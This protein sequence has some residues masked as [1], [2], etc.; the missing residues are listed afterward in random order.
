MHALTGAQVGASTDATG[1]SQLGGNWTLERTTG[2]LA[3]GAPFSAASI[4]AFQGV[5]DTPL[6]T[7]TFDPATVPGDVLLG[8]T[9][10][11]T[12]SFTNNATGHVCYAKTHDY[13][14]GV[15][16]GSKKSSTKFDV[17]A[18]CETGASKAEVVVN[19]LASKAKNVTLN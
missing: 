3:V 17:P 12:V 5:L 13:T 8:S 10:T 1:A 11:E 16:D 19:G 2:V 9:F 7:V 18:S 6:P 14:T 4:A 15:S